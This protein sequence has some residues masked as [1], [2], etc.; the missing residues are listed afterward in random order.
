M[1]IVCPT[2]YMYNNT[3]HPFRKGFFFFKILFTY[4]THR[5]RESAQIGR[6]A[7][8]AAGR[9]RGR[10]RLSAEQT[11]QHGAQTQDPGIMTRAKGR[12]LTN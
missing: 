10:T 5:D 12:H 2:T 8:R 6:V 4:L 9:G 3:T 11:A 7:D 1:Y